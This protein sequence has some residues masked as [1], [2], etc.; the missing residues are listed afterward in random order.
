[1]S[2]ISTRQ[3]GLYNRYKAQ[4]KWDH[5]DTWLVVQITELEEQLAETERSLSLLRFAI[6]SGKDLSGA[7]IG[8][9]K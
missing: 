6:D 3:S 5:F 2:D 7:A 9:K 8:E 4:N 1:M